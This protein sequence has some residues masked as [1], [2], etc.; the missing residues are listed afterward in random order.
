MS[1]KIKDHTG[2]RG[3]AGLAYAL[4][5][6]LVAV[7]AIAAVTRLGGGVSGLMSKVGNNLSNANNTTSASN[8]QTPP[9]LPPAL[10]VGGFTLSNAALSVNLTVPAA[11][12]AA[13]ASG[14]TAPYVLS[15]VS[16]G[17]NCTAS[18][19][20][21]TVTL[22]AA[23]TSGSCGYVVQ[24]SLGATASGS[25]GFSFATSCAGLKSGFS[26]LG[27]AVYTLLPSTGQLS[28]YCDMTADGGGWTLV[29]RGSGQSPPTFANWNTSTGLNIPSLPSPTQTT[30]FKY[31]DSI[32]NALRGSGG[33]YR[34]RSDGHANVTRFAGAYTYQHA[35]TTATAGAV[36]Q[37]SYSDAGLTSG[38]Y[39]GTCSSG[40]RGFSD[41]QCGGKMY[42]ILNYGGSC[43]GYG[44]ISWW[45]GTGTPIGNVCRVGDT[46]E[47]ADFTNGIGTVSN[48]AITNCNL[49]LWV[50]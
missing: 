21:G 10:S 9:P 46:I 16:S 23:A 49:T 33:I 29:M 26:S 38:T 24:D 2:R 43:C 13:T 47:V 17:S 20:A 34:I 19:S 28:V 1:T 48:G 6:G 42:F 8:S 7:V 36:A 25:I 14:G 41:E 22:N 45:M 4:V 30:T 44:N 27:S 5:V 50:R 40:E 39:V 12:L 3:S 15:S 31:S 18:L 37:T 32:I 11:T 35:T